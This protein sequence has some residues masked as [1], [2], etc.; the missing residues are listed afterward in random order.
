LGCAREGEACLQVV[1]PGYRLIVQ[2]GGETYEYHAGEDRI[3]LCQG[4]EPADDWGEAQPLVDMALADLDQRAVTGRDDIEIISVEAVDW[5]DACL[6]CA[7]KG[8]ACATVITP[9]YRLLLDVGGQT[10]EYHTDMERVI[11]CQEGSAMDD[12]GEAQ[13][14]VD[15]VVTDLAGRLKI[16]S[17][18]IAVSQVDEK[19]WRDSSL[20]CPQPGQMYLQVIT[21]GY[22]IVLEVQGQ[23]YI[24]HTD[25]ESAFILC[26]Q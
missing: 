7:K 16:E 17:E 4:G 5:P 10:Y 8:E 11:L 24:Y 6:G 21:S 15:L 12:W 19:M 2:V 1:T 22:R 13:A 9:G 25:A 20:G 26:E 3:I 18:E 23:Q 14:L